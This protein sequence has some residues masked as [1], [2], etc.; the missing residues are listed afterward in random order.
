MLQLK[1]TFPVSTVWS[2]SFNCSLSI[3]SSFSAFLRQ[4]VDEEM[5]SHGSDESETFTT[6]PGSVTGG[7][8]SDRLQPESAEKEAPMEEEQGDEEWKT[9]M[10]E[11]V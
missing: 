6:P 4:V 8:E 3:L 10:P 7:T 9:I 1:N 5:D 11:V 2:I